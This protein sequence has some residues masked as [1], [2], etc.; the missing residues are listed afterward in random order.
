MSL[1]QA[2]SPATSVAVA[3][4][5]R[6][7]RAVADVHESRES[8]PATTRAWLR[9]SR[10][11]AGNISASEP[12]TKIFFLDNADWRLLYLALVARVDANECRNISDQI[13]TVRNI[14]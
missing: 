7:L 5:Q 3:S 1:G 9:R 13:A 4:N 10:T 12:W 2:S 14:T 6:M 11:S 8:R